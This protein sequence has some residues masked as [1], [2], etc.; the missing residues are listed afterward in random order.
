MVVVPLARYE[1]VPTPVP[2]PGAYVISGHVEEAGVHSGDASLVMPSPWL[3]MEADRE[4]GYI[5]CKPGD[6]SLVM[7]SPW[8][9]MEAEASSWA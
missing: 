1:A 4:G 7:P 2:A 3:S 9:S 6:A 8:L 5:P